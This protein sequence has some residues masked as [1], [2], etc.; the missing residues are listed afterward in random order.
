MSEATTDPRENRIRE[1]E[2]YIRDTLCVDCGVEYG[3][4]EYCGQCLTYEIL[5]KGKS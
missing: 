4:E 2:D 3:S 5:E 1:L